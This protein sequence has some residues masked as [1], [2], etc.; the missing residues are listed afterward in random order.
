MSIV[1][2]QRL[3]G[4]V[5]AV[6]QASREAG[7]SP[8]WVALINLFLAL[9]G[10][11]VMLWLFVEERAGRMEI[12]RLQAQRAECE[13]PI[14][15]ASAPKVVDP[16]QAAPAQDSARDGYLGDQGNEVRPIFR[17]TLEAVRGPSNP[18]VAIETLMFGSQDVLPSNTIHVVNL[19]ATWCDPCKD[20]MPDL[21]QLFAQKREWK[22]VRF[23]PVLVKDP[24]E[25]RKAYKMLEDDMPPAAVKLAD[26]GLNDP[27]TTTLAGDKE[28]SLFKGG[29]PVTLVLDC[30]RRVRW[31][32]FEQL[33][34][35]D[36]RDL[37]RVVDEL[38]TELADAGPGAWCTREW[39]GNGRCEEGE[40][41]QVLEDCGR[42]APRPGEPTPNTDADSGEVLPEACPQGTVPI[43]G[44]GCKR[45]LKGT[46]M[47]V[48]KNVP[49][50]TCGDGTCSG[51]E[52]S[53]NCC[54]DCG[55][56]GTQ[57]CLGT[58]GIR[59]CRIRLKGQSNSAGSSK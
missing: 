43:P 59:V 52:T 49:L 2:R 27:L 6:P 41:G 50:A 10:V 25:P 8:V 58:P 4:R 51:S 12:A 15:R 28:G 24:S 46:Q 45:A 22:D 11:A 31:A 53:E 16:E 1:A 18:D 42:L 29:L 3:K 55:C 57:V 48:K 23:V 32:H 56:A 39:A 37:E 26:R 47:P 34:R 38:Q 36:I 17:L 30:N 7:S 14:L 9:L 13:R 5:M 44:G 20:E 21:K 33:R 54:D 40:A 19:W 35:A